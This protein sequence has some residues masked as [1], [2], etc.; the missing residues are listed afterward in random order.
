MNRHAFCMAHFFWEIGFRSIVVCRF[1]GAT[2]LSSAEA[3]DTREGVWRPIAS[4]STRRSSVG[5]AVLG[6]KLYAVG[7]Y[8]G[9][10]RQ[11]LHTVER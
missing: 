4:M 10:S 1:D 9:A 6:G 5:V 7:G 11:C 2:G 8:D 3:L